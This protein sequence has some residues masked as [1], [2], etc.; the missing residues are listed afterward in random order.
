MLICEINANIK[1]KS[2][3]TNTVIANSNEKNSNPIAVPR[4]IPANEV[5]PI[6]AIMVFIT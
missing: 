6:I 1:D 4:K 5:R 2:E 3:A